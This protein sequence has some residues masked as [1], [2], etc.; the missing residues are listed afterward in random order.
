MVTML[1]AYAQ[2]SVFTPVDKN[3]YPNNMTMVVRLTDGDA[4]EETAELAAF[5]NGECRGTARATHGLYY[6]VISGEGAGQPMTLR[7]CRDGSIYAI[8]DTQQFVS[9]DNIG[10]SWEPYVID[11]QGKKPAAVRGDVNGD[12]I[13]NIVD[14]TTTI[15]YV[16]AS[17]PQ[18][19]IKEAA[20]TNDD[21]VVNIVDVVT[22][23]DMIL[24]GK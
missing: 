4:T 19:F 13:V 22:I 7:I 5:V 23:I 1:V 8:D 18:T 17:V 6:L 20:D 21:G 3:L 10:T 15:S 24:N 14:L 11:L 16:L 9:D 2:E 12:G